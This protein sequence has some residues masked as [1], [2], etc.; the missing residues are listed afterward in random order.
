MS[1]AGSLFLLVPTSLLM[2]VFHLSERSGVDPPQAVFLRTRPVRLVAKG[3]LSCI[4]SN[5]FDGLSTLYPSCHSFS[6]YS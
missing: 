4:A 6:S 1:A 2:I 5:Y 3:V